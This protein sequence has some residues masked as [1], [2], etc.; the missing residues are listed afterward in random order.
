MKPPTRTRIYVRMAPGDPIIELARIPY[1]ATQSA[2]TELLI[3]LPP[4]AEFEI[5]GRIYNPEDYHTGTGLSAQC[6]APVPKRTLRPDAGPVAQDWDFI[7]QVACG[8][9]KLID[10]WPAPQASLANIIATA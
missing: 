10:A 7:Q 5:L 8:H 3:G 4:S 9:V 1:G 2:I 6:G